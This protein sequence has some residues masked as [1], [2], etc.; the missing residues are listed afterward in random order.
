MPTGPLLRSLLF[1]SI[2]SSPLLNPC[3]SMLTRVVNSTSPLLDPSQNPL[4]NHLLRTTIYN[5]FCAGENEHSVQQTVHGMKTLGFKGVIMGYAKETVVKENEST[6][7][8]T[9]QEEASLRSVEEWKRGN[10]RTLGMIGAG[11]YLAVKFTGAG[12]IA[13]NALASGDA[14]PQC[15]YQ[16][17]RE[18]CQTAAVFQPAID[19]WTIELMREF[20]RGDSPVVFNTIQAYLK[21][22]AANVQ[23]HLLLSKQEGW[24][25]GI[26]LVRG[27]YIAHDRRDRI[28]DTKAET[29]ANYNSIVEN[30]LQRKYPLPTS[31]QQSEFPDI[32]LFVASHNSETVRKAYTLHRQLIKSG[33]PTIPIEFG[34]LQGMADEIGC[35]LVQQN[36]MDSRDDVPGVFKCLAWG[37]TEEC[38]HYLLR[39]AVENKGAVQRTRDMAVALRRELWRRLSFSF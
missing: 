10:L 39:R 38:L 26:K 11:D 29:D 2:M 9:S 12:P 20:N 6:T 5:H 23:R 37:T 15:I 32:R 30:L 25:L 17:M 4:M 36:R 27:A 33:A 3:L 16:A 24:K 22:S 21:D 18:T 14:M 13:L 7:S 34:Q 1:T 19:A 28:H 31:Q 8:S 35:G